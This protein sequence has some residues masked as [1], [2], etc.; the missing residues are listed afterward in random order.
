MCTINMYECVCMRVHM[1]QSCYNVVSPIAETISILV[2]PMKINNTL[3][4]C[5][6]IIVNSYLSDNATLL[7]DISYIFRSVPGYKDIRSFNKLIITYKTTT[8]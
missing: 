2:F 6:I 1:L 4:T 3:L 5:V 7:Y 8:S